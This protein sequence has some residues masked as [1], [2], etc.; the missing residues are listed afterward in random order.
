MS[1]GVGRKPAIMVSF[2]HRKERAQHRVTRREVNEAAWHHSSSFN[3]ALCRLSSPSGEGNAA[4]FEICCNAGSKVGYLL[5][6][7]TPFSL[8][9]VDAFSKAGCIPH[10]SKQILDAACAKMTKRS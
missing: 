7:T 10:T 2:P 4:A 9:K 3:P 8:V 5:H 6:A 1:G